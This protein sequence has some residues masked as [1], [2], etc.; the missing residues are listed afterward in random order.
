MLWPMSRRR[1]GSFSRAVQLTACGSLTTEYSACPGALGRVLGDGHPLG[2]F[3]EPVED[4]VD[5]GAPQGRTVVSAVPRE[6]VRRAFHSWVLDLHNLSVNPSAEARGDDIVDNPLRSKGVPGGFVVRAILLQPTTDAAAVFL[7]AVNATK[8][9]PQPFVML[10]VVRDRDLKPRIR[11]R[12][13]RLSLFR[14]VVIPIPQHLNKLAGFP[15]HEHSAHRGTIRVR[16]IGV[17]I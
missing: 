16:I 4:D 10:A 3:L 11:R 8:K 2:E 15:V 7:L 9:C 13:D 12:L 5:W 14:A 6:D 17:L 1:R